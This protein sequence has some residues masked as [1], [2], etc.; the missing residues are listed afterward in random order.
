M[1]DDRQVCI[2]GEHLLGPLKRDPDGQLRGDEQ[3]PNC[4][5]DLRVDQ[6]R[7]VHEALTPESITQ[8]PVTAPVLQESND[9]R[10]VDDHHN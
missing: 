9:D 3:A 8:R 10:G 7:R 5:R 6:R 2:V 4:G 1:P